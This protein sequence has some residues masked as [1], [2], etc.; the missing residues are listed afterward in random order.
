MNS[1]M[2]FAVQLMVGS[3]DVTSQISCRVQALCSDKPQA[4]LQIRSFRASSSQTCCKCFASSLIISRLDAP[5]HHTKGTVLNNK[6][7]NPRG[8]GIIVN[9]VLL[10]IVKLLNTSKMMCEHLLKEQPAVAHCKE[11]FFCGQEPFVADEY[12]ERLAWRTP[13]GGSRGGEAFDPKR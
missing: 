8:D 9:T 2:C 10:I 5:T 6:Y 1:P 7:V 3:G 11:F 4:Q 12:I 13:G